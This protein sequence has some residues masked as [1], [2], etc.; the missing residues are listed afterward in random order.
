MQVFALGPQANDFFTPADKCVV[1]SM[2]F[3]GKGKRKQSP[4][5]Q[6]TAEHGELVLKK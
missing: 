2:K 4:S 1:E 6:R 5:Y 3:E